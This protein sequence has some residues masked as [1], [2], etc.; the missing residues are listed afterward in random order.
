MSDRVN[1]YTDGG[2]KCDIMVSGE[3]VECVVDRLIRHKYPDEKPKCVDW[4]L[5]EC[6]SGSKWHEVVYWKD[7]C[8]FIDQRRLRKAFNEAITHWWELPEVSE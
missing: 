3:V 7:G 5:V 4:Y 8:F 1:I 2:E 6:V